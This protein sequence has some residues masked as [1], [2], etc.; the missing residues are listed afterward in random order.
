MK[1]TLQD[2]FHHSDYKLTIFKPEEI[3]AIELFE[4]RG[5]PYLRDFKDGKERPAKP[6]EIVRQLVLKR[7]LDYDYAKERISVEKGVWFGSSIHEKAADVVVADK[8]DPRSAY[9]IVEVKRPK[10]KDGI[11]QLKSYCN[12]EGAPIALWT[13]G[14]EEVVLRRDGPNIY[15]NL[16]RL[17]TAHETLAQVLNEQVTLEELAARNKLVTE[18][19]TLKK[20]I[21]DLENLVLANAG[22]DAFE[23]V[24]N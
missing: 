16:S 12:A 4:R 17:P 13:N 22:V 6:E 5:K 1:F 24:F 2:I 18:R 11:E 3:A 21:L 15:L 14:E 7:L 10:R 9:I 8:T 20:I 23:E 19:W